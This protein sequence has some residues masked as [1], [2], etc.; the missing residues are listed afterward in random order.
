MIFSFGHI[1]CDAHP[2]NILIRRHPKDPNKPQ[3][4]LLDH[5]IYRTISKDFRLIFC[6]L[7]TKLMQFDNQSVSKLARILGIEEYAH[8]L[9]ILFLFRTAHSTKEIGATFT[10]VFY[11]PLIKLIFLGRKATFE[12]SDKF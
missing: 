3:L 5:G 1:H 11:S 10:N 8:Y 9:P 4:V 2:G 7:W 6:E 12:K